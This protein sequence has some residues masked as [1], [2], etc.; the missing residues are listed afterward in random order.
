MLF[1]GDE[2]LQKRLRPVGQIGDSE[3]EVVSTLS[4]LA[5]LTAQNLIHS[6]RIAATG[7]FFVKDG[8]V[9]VEFVD[10]VVPP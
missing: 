6:L 4:H 3:V 7:R 2:Y 10:R 5:F 9:L 1:F 8:N